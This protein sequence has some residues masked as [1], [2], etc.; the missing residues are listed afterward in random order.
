MRTSFDLDDLRT[1]LRSCAGEPESIDLASDIADLTFEELGYDSIA[2]LETAARVEQDLGVT[3]E[4]NV[5]A[6]DI[7]TPRDFVAYVST[8]LGQRPVGTRVS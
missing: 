7:T 4:D 3:V 5:V 6:E 2:L 1:L 8:R